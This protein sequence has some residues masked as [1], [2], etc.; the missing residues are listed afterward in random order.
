MK[1]EEVR[2]NIVL[3]SRGE[4]T[5][6]VIVNGCRTSSPSG[7]SKGKYETP[8]YYN[9][10]HWNIH[11]L[12]NFTTKININKFD[13]LR[14]LELEIKKKARLKNVQEF[15]ANALFAFESAV[16]KALAA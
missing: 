4:E 5:I 12:N 7:K 10:I 2:A 6:E 13:D 9:S 3:D 15:G 11:F 16:L 14:K 8:S 1:I